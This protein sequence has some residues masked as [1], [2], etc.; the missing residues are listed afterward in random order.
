ME[1]AATTVVPVEI[2]DTEANE[3]DTVTTCPCM[4]AVGV[5]VEISVWTPGKLIFCNSGTKEPTLVEVTVEA[6]AAAAVELVKA[7]AELVITVAEEAT[8]EE[9]ED[10]VCS[11]V[12][13]LVLDEVG[14]AEFEPAVDVVATSD[15]LEELV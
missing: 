11:V 5:V 12:A 2:W 10:E 7:P 8:G 14:V 13:T 9:E 3:L 15:E 6:E 4:V 1:L